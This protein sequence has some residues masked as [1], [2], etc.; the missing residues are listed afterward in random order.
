ME[1]HILSGDITIS[2]LL[3]AIGLDLSKNHEGR[4]KWLLD[5]RTA[6]LHATAEEVRQL[7]NQLKEHREKNH[8]DC[9]CKF[10]AIAEDDVTF[11]LLRIFIVYADSENADL[12]VCRE[13]NEAMSWLDNAAVA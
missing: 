1:H 5:F 6:K 12:F 8:P 4:V 7:G 10:A 11:G 13:E 2:E 3:R 9:N